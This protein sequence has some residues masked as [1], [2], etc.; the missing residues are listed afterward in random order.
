MGMD[1]TE[2]YR[3]TRGR[4]TALLRGAGPE[5]ADRRVPG[6]PGVDGA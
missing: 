5:V 2:A 4:I 1:A 3:A 6:L